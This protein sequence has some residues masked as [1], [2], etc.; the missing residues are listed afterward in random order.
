MKQLALFS[1]ICALA[2]VSACSNDTTSDGG[3]GAAG[4]ASGG[5]G[6]AGG[7]AA[8]AAGAAA[9][10]SLAAI[11][12]DIFDKSCSFSSC[13]SPQGAG[14]S[15]DLSLGKSDAV[16]SSAVHA[17]LVGKA[18]SIDPSLVL[19]KAGDADG[20]FLVAKLDAGNNAGKFQ[21]T[22]CSQN[23]GD[24]MPLGSAGLSA[25]KIT[26]IRNWINQGAKDN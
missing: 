5:A 17:A 1:L 21:G 8:G 25:E 7:A 2:A 10:E 19:V 12:K 20:S 24:P 13:H 18:A 3:A 23:C 6:G 9:E 14:S 16:T 4:E 26:R 15:G 11:Q 22:S